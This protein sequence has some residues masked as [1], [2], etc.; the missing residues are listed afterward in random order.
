MPH[1]DDAGE[2]WEIVVNGDEMSTRVMEEADRS[3]EDYDSTIRAVNQAEEST[4]EEEPPIHSF[5]YV[6]SGL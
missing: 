5:T 3:M 1:N 4:F 2:D 6:S